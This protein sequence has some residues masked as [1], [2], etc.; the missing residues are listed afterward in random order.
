[1]CYLRVCACACAILFED[2]LR[3]KKLNFPGE[4][5]KLAR[6]SRAFHL[7]VVPNCRYE[8]CDLFQATRAVPRSRLLLTLPVVQQILQRPGILMPF[9]CSLISILS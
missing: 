1:M 7:I 6:V 8:H 4:I 2:G 9:Q 3:D 5:C